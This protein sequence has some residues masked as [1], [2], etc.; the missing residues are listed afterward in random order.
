MTLEEQLRESLS[1]DKP[2]IEKGQ[3]DTPEAGNQ[4]LNPQEEEGHKAVYETDKRWGQ[5]WKTPEDIYNSLVFEEKNNK[6]LITALQQRNIKDVNGLTQLL[7][8]FDEY[9]NPNSERNVV[10]DAM[11]KIYENPEL[12]QKMTQFFQGLMEEQEQARFGAVL[13][14]EVR[15]KL[16]KVDELEAREQQRAHQEE[17]SNLQK[18]VSDEVDKINKLCEQYGINPDISQYLDYFKN[19]GLSVKNIY[20]HFISMHLED[21]NKAV[22][23]RASSNTL[24][25]VEETKKSSIVSSGEKKPSSG[26]GRIASLDDLRSKISETLTL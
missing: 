2:T 8:K 6:P 26:G 21:I 15:Q 12:S 20:D 1:D 13:P 4:D 9:E 24:K 10:Y 23:E 17:V 3:N 25:N 16:N 14:P 5:Y 19:T 11:Q 18:V 22:Q 7:Q